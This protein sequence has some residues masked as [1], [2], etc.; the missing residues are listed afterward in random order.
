MVPFG[1]ILLRALE[2]LSHVGFWC[3]GGGLSKRMCKG[4]LVLLN[5]ECKQ[6]L[7]HTAV[8]LPNDVVTKAVSQ[9]LAYGH[10]VHAIQ[11]F[12]GTLAPKC[13]V[14]FVS[15]TARRA[16][17]IGTRSKSTFFCDQQSL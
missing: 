14:H 7:R 12:Y 2:V 15:D 8:S 10:L 17:S 13:C 3:E 1:E 16:Y 5:T 4:T 11:I 6:L 9:M